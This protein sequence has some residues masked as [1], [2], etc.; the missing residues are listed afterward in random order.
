MKRRDLLAAGAA[1][2]GGVALRES[3]AAEGEKT[4]A[5]RLG[6]KKEDRLLLLHADDLGMCHSVNAASTRALMEGAVSCGSVMA[7]CP[8]FP[9]I[10]AWAKEHPEADLGVHLALTSE[11]RYYRWRPVAPPGEVKGL[12][13]E[14]G[15]LWRSVPQVMLHASP[16]EVE[17][18]IRAQIQRALQFG[19]KPTHADSHMGTLFAHARFFDAYVRVCKELGVLPMLPGP[20]PEVILQAKLMGLDYVAMME[21]LKGEGLVFLDRLDRGLKGETYEDRKKEAYAYL[22]ALPPGVTELIV[23]LSGDDEEIRHVTSAWQARFNDF[24]IFMDMD[25]RALIR[26]QGVKLIGYR[27]LAALWKKE[28]G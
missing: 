16:A 19:M 22:R 10:A 11:W 1:A 24:R 7:P 28:K 4:L 25:T 3:L 6:F 21:R 12:L 14:D 17:T 18:E 2:F 23:H 9:E 26:E 20:T 15:F 5:E 13:D 8:W 27:P